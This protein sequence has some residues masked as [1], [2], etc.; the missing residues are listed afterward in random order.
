MVSKRDVQKIKVV[1]HKQGDKV[2]L[3]KGSFSNLILTGSKLEKSNRNMLGYSVFKP[4]IDTKQKIHVEAEELAYVVSGSGKITVGNE[5]ISFSAGDSLFIPPGVPHGVR[6]DGS[7]DV[8][9]VFFF[10]SSEYP[11]TVDA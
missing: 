10:S 5:L 1:P 2:D 4:G 6:N 8:A 7:E 3:G 9:M 11:K